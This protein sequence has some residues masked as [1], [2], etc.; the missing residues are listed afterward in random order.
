MCFALRSASRLLPCSVNFDDGLTLNL[1]QPGAFDDGIKPSEKLVASCKGKSSGGPRTSNENVERIRQSF[2]RSARKS[3]RKASRELATI[4]PTAVW[5]VLRKRPDNRKPRRIH[6]LQ[7]LHDGDAQRT[8][9][10]CT[11]VLEKSEDVEQYYPVVSP[12]VMWPLFISIVTT[13]EFGNWRIHG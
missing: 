4:S 2:V 10:F 12:S 5:R 13:C 11:F 8:I 9:G 7:A 1:R 6:L 3:V